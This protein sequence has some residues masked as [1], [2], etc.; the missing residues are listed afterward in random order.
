MLRHAVVTSSLSS[1]AERQLLL[2]DDERCA[3]LQRIPV[4]E[5]ETR[6]VVSRRQA[7]R[8]IQQAVDDARC[9]PDLGAVGVE[10]LD[11]GGVRRAD[12]K[13][14]DPVPRIAR[15]VCKCRNDRFA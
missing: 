15:R 12:G 7:A 6:L 3:R 5:E 14:T 1:R 11:V 10:P 8:E 4:R 2:G 13:E 9:V